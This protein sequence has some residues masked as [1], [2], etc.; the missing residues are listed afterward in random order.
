[1]ALAAL[2]AACSSKGP[3]AAA[4]PKAEAPEPNKATIWTD[5]AELYLEY[6]PLVAGQKVRFAIHLTRLDN[7]RA[8]KSGTCEV[9]LERGEANAETFP[10][11]PSTHPGI[12]GANVQ[13]AAPGE[14]RMS[15][16]VGGPEVT[17][18]FQVGEV[19][20][21]PDA[22]SAERKE[23]KPTEETIAFSKEQQWA[24]DYATEVIKDQ[25]LR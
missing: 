20:V 24:L 3:E 12:F 19:K 16:R 7:F 17:E 15:I 5:K 1:M 18:Q 13:P 9:R 25:T 10:C 22:A 11:D 8:L 21:A 14:A 2:L 23:E 4:P 6:P